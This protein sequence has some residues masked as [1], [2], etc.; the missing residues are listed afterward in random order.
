MRLTFLGTGAAG[1]TP[2]SGR[3]RRRESSLLIE[4][5]SGTVLVDATSQLE[6]QIV[7]VRTIDAVVLTHAH[8][9]AAGGLSALAR[10][11]RRH[12][13][14]PV[15]LL[16]SPQAIAVIERRARRPAPLRPSAVEPGRPRRVAGLALSAVEVP[17]ARDPRYRTYAWRV[18]NGRS[19][20]VYASD[21]A[22]VEAPLAR[23]TRRAELLVIDGAMWRKT[24]FS[25]LTIDRELPALCGWPVDRILLTQIGRTAPP[26]EQLECAVHAL[27]PKAAPAWD[28]MIVELPGPRDRRGGARAPAGAGAST[29]DSP[30]TYP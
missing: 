2:G 26:H 30:R 10:W 1:G 20:L 8:R 29:T 3:S 19:T 17:H 16:A 25:H 13:Q 5:D 4:S 22:A 24:L 14:R 28:G 15:R 12:A 21:V 6:E 11:C 27:C 9:D 7:G 23:L 18:S